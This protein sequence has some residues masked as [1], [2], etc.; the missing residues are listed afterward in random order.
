MPV[1]AKPTAYL[2]VGKGDKSRLRGSAYP[3]AGAEALVPALQA[4]DGALLVCSTSRLCHLQ[5]PLLRPYQPVRLPTMDRFSE[6]MDGLRRVCRDSCEAEDLISFLHG[7]RA[8][9]FPG[10][11]GYKTYTRAILT[12]KLHRE[13]FRSG[14]RVPWPAA[15]RGAGAEGCAPRTR[16]RRRDVSVPFHN[17]RQSKHG[18]NQAIGT[19]VWHGNAYLAST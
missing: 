2:T 6:E 5:S 3:C 10:P 13:V 18:N 15:Q 16:R 12:H 17:Q 1:E 14:V 7:R 19:S 8:G 4:N 11:D 9:R